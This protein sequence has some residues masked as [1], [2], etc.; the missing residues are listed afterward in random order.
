[1][2]AFVEAPRQLV[3]TMAEMRFPARTD[4]RMQSL[5]DRNNEGQLNGDEK[6][7]LES[8]VEL[9]ESISLIRAQALRLLGRRP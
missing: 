4:R 8:L 2:V 3:E 9:S 1:M 6:E 7:E 5:M